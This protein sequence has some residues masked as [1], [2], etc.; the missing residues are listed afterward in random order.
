MNERRLRR[1]RVGHGDHCRQRFELDDD[2]RGGGLRLLQRVGGD[3]GDRLA[4]IADETR[5]E[6]RMVGDAEP[7]ALRRILGH[8]DGAHAWHFLRD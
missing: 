6:E 4:V 7:M 2:R 8:G 5:G 1:Q 3:H